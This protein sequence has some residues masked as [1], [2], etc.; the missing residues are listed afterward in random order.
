MCSLQLILRRNTEWKFASHITR[1]K[2]FGRTTSLW[3]FQIIDNFEH[4]AKPVIMNRSQTHYQRLKVAID[5][6]DEQIRKAFRQQALKCHPDKN[7]DSKEE[8]TARFKLLLAAYLVLLSP[9]RR[10]LYD[11]KLGLKVPKKES[12]SASDAPGPS[13]Q[14]ATPAAPAGAEH[15]TYDPRPLADIFSPF[16][17]RCCCPSERK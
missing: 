10:A 6:T 13:P 4:S 7:P 5:A 2:I 15:A 12:P 9:P 8:A 17:R 16:P 1:E 14:P 3:S 11:R